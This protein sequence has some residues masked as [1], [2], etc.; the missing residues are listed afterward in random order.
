M[1]EPP[2]RDK[3]TEGGRMRIRETHTGIWRDG[4]RPAG[5]DR[6]R[7]RDADGKAEK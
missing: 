1:E 4:E 6:Q 2:K 7:L 3:K 5:R